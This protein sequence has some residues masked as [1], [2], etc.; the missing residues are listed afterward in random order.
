MEDKDKL[1]DLLQEALKEVKGDE[2]GLD[3]L[4]S[5]VERLAKAVESHPY[6][7]YPYYNP[8]PITWTYT[9]T[10]ATSDSIVVGGNP[11]TTY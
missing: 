5:A 8:S 9:D 6:W 2:T 7:Y 4:A 10:G 11:I 1:I 3:R